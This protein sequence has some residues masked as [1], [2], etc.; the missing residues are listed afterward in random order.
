MLLF[1]VLGTHQR[2]EHL[3]ILVLEGETGNKHDIWANYRG[4]G[5]KS[6]L[7]KKE[8]AEQGKELCLT[9]GVGKLQY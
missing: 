2:T 7:R 9:Q 3:E 8:P 1:W 5:R 6:V 4:E